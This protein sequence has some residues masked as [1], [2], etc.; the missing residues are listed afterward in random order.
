MGCQIRTMG[1]MWGA[2]VDAA[3]GHVETVR[4]LVFDPLTPAQ[5]AQWRRI[6]AALLTVLD[7]AGHRVQR[8]EP[9]RGQ[10]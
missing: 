10:T 1:M 5:V 2:V 3:P 9:D 4:H 7:P 8:P 6:A